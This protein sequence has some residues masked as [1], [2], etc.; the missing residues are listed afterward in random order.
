VIDLPGGDEIGRG[1]L[2]LIAANGKE[3]SMPHLN[4]EKP[5]TCVLI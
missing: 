2:R 4:F 5:R 1:G 3:I